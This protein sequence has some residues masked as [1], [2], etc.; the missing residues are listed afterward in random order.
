[1]GQQLGQLIPFWGLMISFYCSPSKALHA[2]P[3]KSEHQV[4]SF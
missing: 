2:K 1:M 3:D 4:T